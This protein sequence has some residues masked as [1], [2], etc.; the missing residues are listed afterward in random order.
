MKNNHTK[1]RQNLQ[2]IQ[3]VPHR[4]H[5]ICCDEKYQLATAVLVHRYRIPPLIGFAES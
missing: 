1:T 2:Y 4:E 3:S 5:N